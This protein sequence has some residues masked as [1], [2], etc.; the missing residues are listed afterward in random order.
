MSKVNRNRL[1]IVEWMKLSMIVLNVLYIY[2][3]IKL[4][5]PFVT[6]IIFINNI[7]VYQK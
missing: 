5:I 1:E 6:F 7:T 4:F 3:K 2:F